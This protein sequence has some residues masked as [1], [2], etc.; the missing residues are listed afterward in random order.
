VT[1]K[2][3][4]GRLILIPIFLGCSYLLIS[5][6]FLFEPHYVQIKVNDP[7]GYLNHEHVG[8]GALIIFA[9]YISSLFIFVILSAFIIPSFKLLKINIESKE[10]YQLLSIWCPIAMML[11]ILVYRFVMNPS[12]YFLNKYDYFGIAMT[13]FAIFKLI[14]VLKKQTF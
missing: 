13:I 1:I 14:P 7:H 11:L 5:L 8:V 3:I 9:E 4:L 12:I 2:D 6:L 10:I